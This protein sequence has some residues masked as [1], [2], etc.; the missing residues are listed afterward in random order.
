M[1]DDPVM[2]LNMIWLII[3]NGIQLSFDMHFI[4]VSS[5]IEWLSQ[6]H[7]PYQLFIF[8]QFAL[9]VAGVIIPNYQMLSIIVCNMHNEC[10]INIVWRFV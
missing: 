5:Y 4:Q 2:F 10:N 7:R 1:F 3:E 8:V 9:T 6:I